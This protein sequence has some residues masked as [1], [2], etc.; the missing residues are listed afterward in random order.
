MMHAFVSDRE[1]IVDLKCMI[2]DISKGGCRIATSYI[3]DLPRIIE[4]TP[5]GFDKPMSGKIIWRNSKVAGVQFLSAAELE[6]FERDKPTRPRETSAAGFFSKLQSLAGLRRRSGQAMRDENREP[7]GVPS[8]GIRVLHGVRNPLTAIKGLL[9]LLMGETIRPIPKKARTII[10]TAHENAEKAESLVEEALHADKMS[11]GVLPFS[12][13]PVEIVALV[14]NAAL[15]NTG[16]AAKNDV[17]FEIKNDVGNAMIQADP[18]R[19]DEVLTNLLASAAKYSPIAEM[20]TVTITRVE[21]SIRVAVADRGLGSNV[22]HGDADGKHGGADDDPGTELDMNICRTVLQQH[23]SE[24][25][26]DARPGTGTTVWF[27][28]PESE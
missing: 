9:E 3:Q 7:I 13:M 28:L 18:V 17:R 22:W 8:F 11:L 23:G 19:L 2:R 21:G 5:E 15:V 25:H 24:L 6:D 16:F 4:I 10:K 20:V 26:I 12:I 14:S 1:D 27:E